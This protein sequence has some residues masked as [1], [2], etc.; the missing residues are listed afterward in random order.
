[1]RGLLVCL[2]L[3]CSCAKR[4][5]IVNPVSAEVWPDNYCFDFEPRILLKRPGLL[6]WEEKK[7]KTLA[8][9]NREHGKPKCMNTATGEHA[10]VPK[11]AREEL[12]R[13]RKP[14]CPPPDPSSRGRARAPHF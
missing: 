5:A 9:I 1:M 6:C 8:E 4:Q 2:L 10:A 7:G 11:E 3:L 14:I 13:P 12:K